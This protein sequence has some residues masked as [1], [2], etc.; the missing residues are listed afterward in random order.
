MYLVA[1][2]VWN[3]GCAIFFQEAIVI[4]FICWSERAFRPSIYLL[5]LKILKYYLDRVISSFQRRTCRLGSW[6]WA[7]NVMNSFGLCFLSQFL[8]PLHS[9]SLFTALLRFAKNAKCMY[10]DSLFISVSLFT[11]GGSTQVGKE[12]RLLRLL[13]RGARPSWSHLDRQR[14][15]YK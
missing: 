15:Q 8:C 10:D 9:V 2:P 3:H 6:P 7:L 5:I 14:L 4:G 13:L 1:Q 11:G 12:D